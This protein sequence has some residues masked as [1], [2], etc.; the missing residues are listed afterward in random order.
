M[1][2]HEIIQTPISPTISYD[3]KT[4]RLDFDDGCV[5]PRLGLKHVHRMKLLRR[6]YLKQQ[7]QLRELR[8]LMYGGSLSVKQ[9]EV[10]A[11]QAELEAIQ[12]QIANE[13]QAA[14]LEQARKDKLTK[15]ALRYIKR[16]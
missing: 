8:G 11:A 15:N 14:E 13:I 5:T 3:I 16:L 12:S 6:R 10:A 4:N 7:A 9:T 1:R 2:L